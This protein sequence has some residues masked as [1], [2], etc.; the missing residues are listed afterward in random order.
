MSLELQ[1]AFGLRREEAMK[2]QPSYADQ[3]DHITLKASWT[4]GGRAQGHSHSNRGP[5][6]SPQQGKKTRRLWLI[7]PEPSKLCA[8]AEDL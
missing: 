3:K 7:D 4:K 6:G 1:R 8:A 5:A 2:F